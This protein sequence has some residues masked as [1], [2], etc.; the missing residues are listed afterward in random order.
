MNKKN[1]KSV[2]VLT[3]IVFGLVTFL[4]FLLNM[5][6][7]SHIIQ[8]IIAIGALATA[9]Y[10]RRSFEK[11]NQLFEEERLS[12]RGYL[13]PSEKQGGLVD[14]NKKLIINFT[15]YGINT[16]KNIIVDE[17][18]YKK[19]SISKTEKPPKPIYTA[20]SYAINPIPRNQQYLIE[21][22]FIGTF[23]NPT[24]TPLFVIARIKY[25]DIILKK[26]FDDYFYWEFGGNKNVLS[27]IDPKELM[28]I[29][30]ILKFD[31]EFWTYISKDLEKRRKMSEKYET[32]HS[33]TT[34][35]E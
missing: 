27:E 21:E 35:L 34:K 18:I 20:T 12:K 14:N 13:A 8:I 30:N 26:T 4:L 9:Y 11:T 10:A 5:I 7:I 2:F 23:P 25:F 15:N 33:S 17:L 16:I 28:N 6:T 1:K 22:T 3:C 31:E 24:K 29:K 32:M 19:D